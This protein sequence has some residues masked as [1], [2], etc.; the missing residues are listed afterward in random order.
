MP[1]LFLKIYLFFNFLI[2]SFK[3]QVSLLK[4]S[5]LNFS[6]YVSSL[7]DFYDDSEGYSISGELCY[8]PGNITQCLD[9]VLLFEIGCIYRQSRRNF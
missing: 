7:F 3:S 9:K 5:Q 1:S 4:I 2:F 6:I 8:S